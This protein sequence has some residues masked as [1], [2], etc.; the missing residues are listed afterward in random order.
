MIQ[1]EGEETP[2]KLMPMGDGFVFLLFLIMGIL[3]ALVAGFVTPLA[4]RLVLDQ[5]GILGKMRVMGWSRLLSLPLIFPLYVVCIKT[6]KISEIY[7]PSNIKN[8]FLVILLIPIVLVV[9][10]TFMALFQL[11]GSCPGQNHPLVDLVR[12]KKTNDFWLVVAL[13]SIF[14]PLTEEV[15]FRGLLQ[16]WIVSASKGP[17]LG[18]VISLMLVIAQ[19]FQNESTSEFEIAFLIQA[20]FFLT[21]GFFFIYLGLIYSQKFGAINSGAL[22]FAAVHSF[23]WPSPVGLFPLALGLGWLRETTG[24]IWPCIVLH[25]AF[26]SFGTLMINYSV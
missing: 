8:I 16:Y 14:A 13:V 22:V 15:L 9:S 24:R 21:L 11:V 19:G 25:A 20:L 12:S 3:P 6:V 23:A 1:P 17:A 10:Y 7:Q 26:N 5:E 18:W 2:K 4:E